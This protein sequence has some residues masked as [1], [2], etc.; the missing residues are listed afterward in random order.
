[1]A[2]K[3][4]I[5]PRL[6]EIKEGI[7][8]N[9]I[10]LIM[11]PTGSG[12]TIGIPYILSSDHR[13]Y[14]GVPTIVAT[15]SATNYLKHILPS[16]SIGSACQGHIDYRRNDQIVYC[17]HG[18]LA[19]KFIRTVSRILKN[20]ANHSK[21]QWFADVVIVDEYHIQSV[22]LSMIVYLWRYYL[23]LFRANP[24]LPDPPKLV[25]TSAT[26]PKIEWTLPYFP[27]IYE[28]PLESSR[29]PIERIFH[30]T[31][32][33]PNGEARYRIAAEI[34]IGKHS[35][36]PEGIFLIFAPG[37]YEIDLIIRNLSGM[38][39]PVYPLHGEIDFDLRTILPTGRTVVVST[40]VAECS[41]T[42]PGVVLVIDTGTLKVSHYDENESLRLDLVMSPRSSCIQRAGRTG[43][44]CLGKYIYLGDESTYDALSN[45]NIPAI[46]RQPI[47]F[48]LMKMISYDIDPLQV[49]GDI[50]PLVNKQLG[51]LV[52][53]CYLQPDRTITE[54]GKRAIE[55]PFNLR[56]NRVAYHLSEREIRHDD[57]SFCIL[58]LAAIENYGRGVY[59]YPGNAKKHLASVGIAVSDT[60]T[61]VD[62]LISIW[63]ELNMLAFQKGRIR[64]YCERHGIDQRNIRETLTLHRKAMMVAEKPAAPLALSDLKDISTL[65]ADVFQVTHSDQIGDLVSG[66]SPAIKV[67]R[68]YHR[69]EKSSL[70][71]KLEKTSSYIVLGSRRYL[72]GD[73][74]SH[75]VTIFHSFPKKV[76]PRKVVDLYDQD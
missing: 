75:S 61:T 53:N 14:C 27:Y 56:L 64:D 62:Y 34:A 50:L 13:T 72:N 6:R 5:Y 2:K 17:T 51:D 55:F 32:H 7:E 3:L 60:F 57:Y 29:H 40:N 31:P 44:T 65:L 69:F 18:H 41:I 24:S 73:R 23:E 9:L 43:R 30:P 28:H 52:N 58:I 11:S 49:L 12:K 48:Y 70:V 35:T 19:R 71:S 22:E 39:C 1:M 10:S 4:V 59:H 36:E 76:T 63:S 47:Y 67:G 74:T 25:I 46:T 45:D 8:L 38:N 42:I 66:N 21:T 54:L 16:V 26:L 68:V 33:P 37:K 20:S 15:R